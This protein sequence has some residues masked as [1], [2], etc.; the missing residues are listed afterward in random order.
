MFSCT[1]LSA[2]VASP[3]QGHLGLDSHFYSS[4]RGNEPYSQ[5]IPQ[6]VLHLPD[7][8]RRSEVLLH[9]EMETRGQRDLSLDLDRAWMAFPVF[10]AD[11]LAVGRQHPWDHA[12]FFERDR[13]WGILAQTQPQNLGLNLGYGLSTDSREAK[14]ILLGW[15]GASYWS[16][17][18]DK[19]WLALGASF[20]PI[21]VPTLGSS[22]TL[23]ADAPTSTTRF[24]RRPPGFV[25]ID[26][27]VVPLRF[28]VDRSRVWQEVLL[29]PQ[30]LVQGRFRPVRP[31][32]T[33]FGY[34]RAPDP[35]P[36]ID[37]DEF[38]RVTADSVVAQAVIHPRFPQR[39]LVFVSQEW[40]LPGV[41]LFGT[42]YVSDDS[43]AGG[44]VGVHFPYFS[45]SL[46]HATSWKEVAPDFSYRPPLYGAWLAQTELH[47]PVGDFWTYFGWKHHL[48]QGDRWLQAGIGWNV[49]SH[50]A[51]DLR[52]DI[53]AGSDQS[54]FGEWRTNDR[55]G[56]LLRWE[57]GT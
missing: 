26:E 31:L 4:P 7:P 19:E 32:S 18:E 28:E 13:P 5:V 46:G 23:G 22:V 16:D 41:K 38:L 53:F 17:R 8:D 3:Y 43:K 20:T 54:Y 29:R 48:H 25:R 49:T 39:Q 15:I 40:Q 30:V 36:K 11:A 12:D 9:F 52:G 35:D 10:G 6:A 47:V 51:L 14:P 57:L 50:V 37:S 27:S 56:I 1:A 24:G 42:A 55:V 21:F 33:W 45:A 2:A 34:L 44:E